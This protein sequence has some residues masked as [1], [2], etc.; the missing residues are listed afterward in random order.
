M[1]TH[2]CSAC[3]KHLLLVTHV[4]RH[5]MVSLTDAPQISVSISPHGNIQEGT[6]VTLAC[7]ST[8]D[9]PVRRYIWYKT[10]SLIASWLMETGKTYTIKHIK[11]EESG[12]YSCRSEYECGF[13]DSSTHL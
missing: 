4:I 2:S 9:L 3:V 7:T 6:D 8:S 5:G 12:L 10:V 1:E 11:P 13:R